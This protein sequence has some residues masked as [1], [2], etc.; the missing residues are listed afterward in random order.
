[1]DKSMITIVDGGR[2]T[3]NRYRRNR[4]DNFSLK[5]LGKEI[6]KPFKTFGNA[7]ER[8]FSGRPNPKLE[9][10]IKANVTENLMKAGFSEAEAKQA[11]EDEIKRVSK[12]QVNK[13]KIGAAVIAAAAT[14]GALAPAAL[15]GAGAAG[16]GAGAGGA[17][18]GAA[19]ASAAGLAAKGLTLAKA[20]KGATAASGLITA[21][22]SKDPK[23]VAAAAET[24][25]SDT[26][27]ADKVANE[28]GVSQSD[29]IAL[30]NKIKQKDI[31]EK[32]TKVAGS[33]PPE[34]QKQIVDTAK[35]TGK[36]IGLDD[37]IANNRTSAELLPKT[38]KM[39]QAEDIAAI[40]SDTKTKGAI[41]QQLDNRIGGFAIRDILI[42]AAIVVV[43]FL[44]VR[45]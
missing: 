37:I 8:G 27:L 41:E 43:V 24:L 26:K 35:Q 29:A 45:K 30:A 4:Q 10:A 6:S 21:I 33:I 44:F 12:K 18:G 36:K 42:V 19:G 13:A 7:V 1:M 39:K 2:V 17:A 11:A 16:A 9:G 28:L 14:A 31:V 25:A 38:R 23:K 32:V 3:T 22:K 34:I 20:V 15:G 40:S 5:D